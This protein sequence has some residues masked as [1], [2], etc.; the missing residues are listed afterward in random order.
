[1]LKNKIKLSLAAALLSTSTVYAGT[2]TAPNSIDIEVS[3]DAELKVVSEKTGSSKVNKRT[4][5]VNLGLTA[6]L[7]NGIN[8]VTTFKAFDGSQ[9][10][11]AGGNVDDGFKTK[12]AYVSIPLN[13]KTT[14]VAGLA[15]NEPYGTDTDI[16]EDGG[17]SWK[18]SL[19]SQV[20]EN[21]TLSF[22]SAIVNEEEQ[23]SNQGDSGSSEVSVDININELI[24]GAK[25]ANEY[26]NKGDGVIGSE[27]ETS[28]ISTYLTGEISGLV[29]GFEYLLQDVELVGANKT[30]KQ[31]GYFASVGKEIGAFNVG[32]TYVNL[33]KGMK[34]GSEFAPGLILDGNI[35]SSET[36]DTSAFILPVDYAINDVLSANI[37]YIGT[38][39]QG[40]NG[41]EID[42]GATYTIN[43]N[44]ELSTVLGKYTQ[45]NAQDQTNMEVA[46]A[47]TF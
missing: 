22:E 45:D 44:V 19:A 13:E 25:Y 1:M 6:K 38:D 28:V 12:E 14:I 30:T 35:N 39:F 21:I 31:K 27:T 9:A 7:D 43:D 11:T 4:A 18:I 40:D 17:E 10:A 23:N 37:T 32:L 20:T 47:I 46:I 41:K 5:E 42:L 2:V 24:L 36:K 8:V 34:G 26:E 16:F 29:V 3:G 33:S 15:S